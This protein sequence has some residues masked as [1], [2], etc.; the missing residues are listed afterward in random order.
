[1][2]LVNAGSASLPAAWKGYQA[3]ASYDRICWFRVPTTYDDTG[4]LSIQHTPEKV[5]TKDA[6]CAALL[7]CRLLVAMQRALATLLPAPWSW[8]A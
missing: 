4:V 7:A 5:C 2:K 8:I 3:C 1:M 6:H